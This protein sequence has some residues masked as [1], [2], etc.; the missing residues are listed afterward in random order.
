M[1]SLLFQFA[2]ENN[3]LTQDKFIVV[4]VKLKA[5]FDSFETHSK[6]GVLSVNL[7][8]FVSLGSKI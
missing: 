1:R 3:E 7:G 8:G 5:L 4:A 6:D 2:N